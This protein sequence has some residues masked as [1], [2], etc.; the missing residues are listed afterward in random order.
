MPEL[1]DKDYIK[2]MLLAWGKEL[3][4]NPNA[5]SDIQIDMIRQ[6]YNS[7][8]DF[9]TIESEPVRHWRW[10]PYY[11]DESYNVTNVFICSECEK[12]ARFIMAYHE[13]EYGFCPHC[14]ARMDGGAD[15]AESD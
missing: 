5:E 4:E 3:S 14:G 11:S 6:F 12:S 7:V 13:C 2:N 9:P 8:R 15:N 10:I 1:I